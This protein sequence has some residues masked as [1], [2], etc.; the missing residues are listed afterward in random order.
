MQ[1]QKIIKQKIVRKEREE[2]ENKSFEQ[3]CVLHRLVVIKK[4]SKCRTQE[5]VKIKIQNRLFT[6]IATDELK[7]RS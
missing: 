5:K 2:N 1:I 6:N 7:I 4:N 3:K